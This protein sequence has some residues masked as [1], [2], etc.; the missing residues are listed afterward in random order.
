MAL[1][2]LAHLSRDL[3]TKVPWS[4][5]LQ[6][7]TRHHHL[8]RILVAT[9]LHYRLAHYDWLVRRAP[10]VDVIAL[11]GD[12]AD[13]ANPVPLGVQAV[14]LDRYLDQLA[15]HATV[16]VVSGNHDLD[17]PGPDG[18]QVAGW[19]R[20]R[21]GGRIHSDG[22]SFDVDGLRFTMCPWWDGPIT[23]GGVGEQLAAAAVDRPQ[24][25]VWL[26]H[27]PPAGTVLCRDGRREFPD[28]Q[29]AAWIAEHRPD[30]VLSGHIHQAP[31]IDGGSWHDRL[32]STQV[33][34][35]G[36]QM[37]QVPPHITLDTTARTADWFGVFSSESVALD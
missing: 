32:G 12:L 37:G 6:M 7:W 35:P 36:R 5:A 19:L 14:V 1:A 20:R 9:D 4:L 16:L 3:A 18:E 11:T 27:A 24:R 10:D 31:W 33:F 25:W 28:H 22:T 30:I 34:N 26:Y 23:R 21:R 8:V 29:L 13:V 17:G 15:E 2:S